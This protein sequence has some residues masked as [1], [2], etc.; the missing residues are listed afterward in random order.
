M[1]ISTRV[2][3]QLLEEIAE[4][5]NLDI[6]KKKNTSTFYSKQGFREISL[7]MV[8]IPARRIVYCAVEIKLNPKVML[9]Q[10]E[11]IHVTNWSEITRVP[12]IFNH[13]LA[14]I[15]GYRIAQE[16]PEFNCWKCKRI[17]YAIDITNDNVKEY[18]NLFQRVKAPN[19]YFKTI[20]TREGS[21]YT[22]S[23]SA[24][25]NFYDK[26]D[27]ISKRIEDEYTNVLESDLD[28]AENILRF[29]VQCNKGKINSIKA[30]NNFTNKDISNFLNSCIGE[31]IILSYYDRTIGDGD[32]YCL[33]E[34][35]KI[36]KN[37]QELSQ[38]T[39]NV[40]VKTLK[41]IAQARDVNKAKKQFVEGVKLKNT[42]I[43]L[44]GTNRTFNNHIRQIQE[45]NINP[46]T[47]PRKW[48]ISRLINLRQFILQAV[49]R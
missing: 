31:D 15:L 39:Q 30:K 37:Q 40:L 1:L 16:L 38:R 2:T 42:N 26:K 45:L 29:E 25:I 41:L 17:D 27:E 18:I 43:K 44:K 20:N 19:I 47:I 12:D 6:K 8:R 24:R 32:F 14:V 10:K 23:K 22:V 13:R 5:L 7:I 33:R 11:S 48:G 35:E 34:A 3:F 9:E 21:A 49:N 28:E 46:V 36:I 4:K